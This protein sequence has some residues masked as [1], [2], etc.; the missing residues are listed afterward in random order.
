[1]AEPSLHP[2][3]MVLKVARRIVPST[4]LE[5]QV[6]KGMVYH[7]DTPCCG[8]TVEAADLQT[9]KSHKFD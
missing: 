2:L 6:V 3:A 7:P 5:K 8:K 1:M 4:A 9:P